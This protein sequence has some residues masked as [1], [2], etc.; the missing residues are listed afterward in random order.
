MPG[1]AMSVVCERMDIRTSAETKAMNTRTAATAGMS[2]GAFLL[3]RVSNRRPFVS[4]HSLHRVWLV[5]HVWTT[6]YVWATT[7]GGIGSIWR[8]P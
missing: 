5:I 8:L 7:V 4:V 2:V 3:I 6:T 1:P